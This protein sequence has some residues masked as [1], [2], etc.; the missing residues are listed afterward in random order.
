[1]KVVLTAAFRKQLLKLPQEVQTQSV[2][3][4][5]LLLKDS[6]HPSLHFKKLA[7]QND[8][9]SIRVS[10]RYRILFILGSD[11][12]IFFAIGHRKDVYQ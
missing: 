12:Y 1:M 4:E 11:K 9:Y 3:Q 5:K 7:G 10:G 6:R 2:K 8:V